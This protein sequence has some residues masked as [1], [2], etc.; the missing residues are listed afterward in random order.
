MRVWPARLVC[1]HLPESLSSQIH[2]HKNLVECVHKLGGIYNAQNAYAGHHVVSNNVVTHTDP[3][4]RL[5]PLHDF[6]LNKQVHGDNSLVTV[7]Q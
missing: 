1:D 6:S 5:F 4:S 7:G 3:L 2:F